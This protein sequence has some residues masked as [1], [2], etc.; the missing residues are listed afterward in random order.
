MA[1][2]VRVDSS[3]KPLPGVEV[4]IEGTILKTTTGENGRYLLS[5]VPAGQWRVLFRLVGHLPVRVGVQLAADDTTRVNAVLIPSTTVLDPIIV[6][7]PTPGGEGRDGFEERRKL[8]FGRF[9]DSLMLRKSEH[10]R[11]N[12]VL[13]RQG[14]VEVRSYPLPENLKAWIAFNPYRLS[15]LGGGLNCPMQVYY[16]GTKVGEG[17]SQARPDRWVDLTLFDVASLESIE[18]YRSAAQVP[19]M[20][21]G[22]TAD[23]GVILLW[24][25]QH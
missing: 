15:P 24:S 18:V 6:K 23:C 16:N 8:G 3:G 14:L 22:P 4:L 17:G 19:G 21:S 13:R 1:G 5:G 25:R 7:A 9:Y 12:D 10:L 2:I 20:Y 11:L